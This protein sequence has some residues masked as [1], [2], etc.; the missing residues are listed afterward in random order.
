MT[1]T[2]EL[3]VLLDFAIQLSNFQ[4]CIPTSLKQNH[5]AS[6]MWAGCKRRLHISSVH[7]MVSHFPALCCAVLCYAVLRCAVDVLCC[8]TLC[9]PVLCYAVLCYAMLC[10]AMLCYAMLCYAMLCY[11]MLH[12]CAVLCCAVLC[13][14]VLCCAVLCCAVLCAPVLCAP[15]L[16][17]PVHGFV[18]PSVSVSYLYR[19]Q[20]KI[21]YCF[22]SLRLMTHSFM[23]TRSVCVLGPS[24]LQRTVLQ[25]Y[26]T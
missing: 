9:C 24:K 12:C 8:S 5:P 26:N 7:C 21:S 1:A 13:C 2:A 17:A 19:T 15:V 3:I 18:R 25:I 4:F 14:A 10:Y 23:F 6:V 20:T 22:D 16:C 11:A